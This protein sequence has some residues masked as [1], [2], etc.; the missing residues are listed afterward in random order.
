MLSIIGDLK[1]ENVLDLGCGDGHYTR[2][3]RE[4]TNGEVYGLD[5]SENMIEMAK[6]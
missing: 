2:I 3:M 4:K 6:S 1:N 5:I